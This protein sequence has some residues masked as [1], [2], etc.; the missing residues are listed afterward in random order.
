MKRSRAFILSEQLM[1]IILQTG[2]LLVLC[3]SFYMLTTFYTQTQQIM[4][5]R[6]HAERVISFVDNKIRY[7]GLGLWRCKSPE[8]IGNRLHNV[9]MLSWTAN[10][11]GNN[12]YKLPIS[13]C[14]NDDSMLN[15][16]IPPKGQAQD[17]G[18][19]LTLLYAQRDLSS[20]GSEVISAFAEQK[21][22]EPH[23]STYSGQYQYHEFTNIQLLDSQKKEGSTQLKLVADSVF[24][25]SPSSNNNIKSYA[26]MESVGLPMYMKVGSDNK[27]LTLRVYAAEEMPIIN[28]PAGGELMGLN[29][30]QM[31]VHGADSP[32]GRQFAY[33]ELQTTGGAWGDKYNQEKG[34]LDIY[35]ELDKTR[36][37]FTLWVLA[38]GGYDASA[39]NPRPDAWPKEA[40]PIGTDDTDA[41][42][43]WLAHDYRHHI[44][45]V[46]RASWKP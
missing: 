19:V 33:R 6:N 8:E 28:V 27:S 13:V 35:M 40:T 18:N 34:I 9:K 39:S 20:G 10:S 7:A 42:N 36:N 14:E 38:T 17:T 4:T 22:L 2:F 32:E 21:A 25:L 29:C 1:T 5:A 30:M 12:A 31:F 23:K 43:Q 45:Y 44:V 16:Y 3:M 46:S 11:S 37:T 15:N 41:K 24:N 26:L